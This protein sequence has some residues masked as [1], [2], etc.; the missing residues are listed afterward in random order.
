MKKRDIRKFL[1]K[2]LRDNVRSYIILGILKQGLEELKEDYRKKHNSELPSEKEARF[3]EWKLKNVSSEADG[4]IEACAD[5]FMTQKFRWLP[6]RNISITGLFIVPAMAALILYG[7]KHFSYLMGNETA[8]I[9][10][11]YEG[12]AGTAI[13]I[14]GL[15]VV[16]TATC[17]DELRKE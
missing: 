10:L 14:L 1:I 16:I 7:L 11:S 13:G 17:I 3:M 2:V 5:E 9:G 4:I 6:F 12:L 15:L 8:F